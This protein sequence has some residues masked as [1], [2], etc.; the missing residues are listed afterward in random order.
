VIT[1]STTHFHHI[2]KVSYN[3]QGIAHLY[4]RVFFGLRQA[5]RQISE[6]AR[7]LMDAV[8]KKIASQRGFMREVEFTPSFVD[9]FDIH[10]RARA[11]QATQPHEGQLVRAGDW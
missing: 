8:R 2:Y 5:M 6:D 11:A 10:H 3:A 7:P 9:K 1:L 4:G